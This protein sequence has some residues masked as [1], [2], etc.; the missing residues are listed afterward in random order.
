VA[1]VAA[2]TPADIQRLAR[3]L[4]VQGQ[5]NLALVGPFKKEGRFAG[6]LKL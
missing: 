5:L 2:V 6:V 1:Q 3:Q 4:F